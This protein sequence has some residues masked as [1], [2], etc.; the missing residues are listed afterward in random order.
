MM[1]TLAQN[2]M[3]TTTNLKNCQ[4]IKIK[5]VILVVLFNKFN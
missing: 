4:V 5:N 3:L 1:T 2:Y